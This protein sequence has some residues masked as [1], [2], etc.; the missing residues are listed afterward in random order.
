MTNR[1][2]ESIARSEARDL[3][4]M[5]AQIAEREARQA[6]DFGIM[7]STPA[8]RRHFRSWQ[9]NGFRPTGGRFRL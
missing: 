9:R 3:E 5:R 4:V 2:A 6:E 8:E 1:S 7:G